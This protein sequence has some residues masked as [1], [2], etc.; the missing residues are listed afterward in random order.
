MFA[1][2]GRFL[3]FWTS[4]YLAVLLAFGAANCIAPLRAQTAPTTSSAN[5]SGATNAPSATQQA[6]SNAPEMNTQDIAAP[7]TVRVNVVPLRVIVRDQN[8]NTVANLQ[9]EN[10][11]LFE[12]GKPQPISNFT[13]ETPDSISKSVVQASTATPARVADSN[14]P[15][16][17]PPSRFI[18]LLFDDA[19]TTRGD[20][21]LA[22]N[23]ASHYVDASLAPTDR[24]AV[25]TISGQNQLDFT[26]DRVKLHGALLQ[27]QP[28]E[29]TAE[30]PNPENDCPPMEFYEANQIETLHDQTAISI[31]TTDA[32]NCE[33]NSI[34]KQPS[35]SDIMRAQA[36]A[37]AAA[38]RVFEEGTE[39][40]ELSFRSLRGAIERLSAMPGQRDIVLISPGFIYPT[41]ESEFSE[42]VDRAI[43]AGVF[44]NTLDAR[45]LYVP[46]L[47]NDI[48]QPTNDPTPQAAGYRTSYRVTGQESQIDA[49]LYL[50]MDTGG[51]AFHGNNDL[52]A[53]MQ[54]IA[55]APAAYYVLAFSPSNL[56]FDGRFH[57]LKVVVTSSSKEKFSVQA[58][59]GFYAP[60]QNAT[61]ADAASEDIEDAVFSQEEQHGLPVSL[62]TQFFK[63]DANDAKLAVMA[64]VDLMQLRFNKA[65]GRNR[66]NLTVVAVLFDRDGNFITG[67]QKV[68][69]MNLRD[70]TLERIGHSGVI[71]RSSFDVKPGDY[72]VRLVV[73]D[74]TAAL[75]SAENGVV[76]IP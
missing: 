52:R 19:R 62:Q 17:L 59:R 13:V 67:T 60:K 15:V 71:V 57:S 58:R 24:V 31:A 47:G 42:I 8:G 38:T 66:N 44:I 46:E 20:L 30:E 36:D 69:E 76:E 25:Y 2:S 74:S 37:T 51:R 10:F 5:P 27:L 9:R 39:K 65:D 49:L 29:V 40:T 54:E 63:T 21:M 3:R 50:A 53:G 28:R 32:L 6:P 11:Q 34:T 7:L 35:S 23:A 12:D 64:R 14:P 61:P 68:L 26:D 70:E 1:R 55:A 43:R 72:V 56:K 16:F 22:R 4:P 41:L 48:S 45:G 18:V 75:L 73:R 33:V